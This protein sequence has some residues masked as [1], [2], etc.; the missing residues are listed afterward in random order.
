MKQFSCFVTGTDTG[1]GKTL[2]T[3]AIIHGLSQQ[4]MTVAG[5]KPVAA[6]VTLQ[7]RQW[8]N[9]DTDAI[10]SASSIMLPPA[11]VTP[12]LLKT[13][14]SPNIAASLENTV[15]QWSRISDSYDQIREMAPS[16]IIEGIGGF[17]VPLSESYTAADLAVQFGL[18]VILVVGL[19]LGC[20]NHAL[21]SAEAILSRGLPLTGWVAN[22][23]DPMMLYDAENIASLEQHI[24]APRLAAIPYIKSASIVEAAKYF[25]FS[26]LKSQ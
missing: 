7:N 21:L 25:D 12:Y 23:I 6:G 24:P 9:E 19:R 3:C 1:V 5:M 26:T 18:P 4:G 11:L 16:V 2:V 22:H 8:H 13:A 17:K 10:I 14:I 15:I 20:L